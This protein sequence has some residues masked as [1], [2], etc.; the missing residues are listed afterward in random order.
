M[1]G[2]G[3]RNVIPKGKQTKG[4]I[5]TRQ[6]SREQLGGREGARG[7]KGCNA[8]KKPLRTHGNICLHMSPP[9]LP[10]SKKYFFVRPVWDHSHFGNVSND[11][12]LFGDNADNNPSSPVT[13]SPL[14]G[15]AQ[16][17]ATSVGLRSLLCQGCNLGKKL[18]M[19]I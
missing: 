17:P 6:N 2:V 8:E 12:G 19:L 18:S 4:H 14:T 7:L 16:F 11:L 13:P 5:D 10:R 15:Q 9:S 3:D 1:E